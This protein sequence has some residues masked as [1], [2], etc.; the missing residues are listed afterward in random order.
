MQASKY[1]LETPTNLT[2]WGWFVDVRPPA[3]R[4]SI[5]HHI[6]ASKVT[7]QRK[8]WDVVS[9]QVKSSQVKH[10]ALAPYHTIPCRPPHG[11]GKR[12]RGLSVEWKLELLGRNNSLGNRKKG[13]SFTLIYITFT[14]LLFLLYPFSP[15]L[16]CSVSH[17]FYTHLLFV[18]SG[19]FFG[20]SIP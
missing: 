4:R 10:T 17:L 12:R 16:L 18:Y 20:L 2:D 3:R 1:I 6:T 13:F 11:M 9:S 14:R 5:W 15:S 7:P 8:S 19:A